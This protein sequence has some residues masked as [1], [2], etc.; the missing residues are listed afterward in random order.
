MAGVVSV[1]VDLE[2]KT[3]TVE[4]DREIPVDDFRAVI[5]EAGYELV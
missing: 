5:V 4:S 3:A 2:Q 1:E